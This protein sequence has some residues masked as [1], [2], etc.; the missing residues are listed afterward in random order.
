M[1]YFRVLPRDLFNEAK[2]LKCLGQLSLLLHNGIRG[3]HSLTLV[4]SE[5]DG[6][7]IEQDRSS[8]DLYC[9]NLKLVLHFPGRIVGREIEL[10][11]SLNSRSRPYPLNYLDWDGG[12]G[13][14]FDDSGQLSAE[15]V[16]WLSAVA[17]VTFGAPP[18]AD[19]RVRQRPGCPRGQDSRGRSVITA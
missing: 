12:E 4:K 17:V 1:S 8:G 13:Y 3:V 14:V 16:D 11:S 6:F 2:L 5:P 18:G 10:R 7:V 9:A 19:T 15:F